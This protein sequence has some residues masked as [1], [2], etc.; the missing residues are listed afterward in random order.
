MA[1]SHFRLAVND[2]RYCLASVG[3]DTRKVRVRAGR[4]DDCWG[5]WAPGIGVVVNPDLQG[6][7]LY[8]VLIHEIGH[9]LGLDHTRSGIMRTHPIRG[10]EQRTELPTATQKKRWV[11][12]I[13]R[14]VVEKKGRKAR[15]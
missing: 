6:E 4:A 13:A 3:L 1:R 7:A 11:M 8:R 5:F 9:A 15:L 12:Q 2:V 10:L 14:L